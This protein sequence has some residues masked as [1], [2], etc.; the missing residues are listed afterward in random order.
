[1]KELTQPSSQVSSPSIGELATVD[2]GRKTGLFGSL[3]NDPRVMFY[4]LLD[5][6]ESF[7]PGVSE[8]LQK[9]IS[10]KTKNDELTR[11]E[12]SL[13]DRAV[14]D[15]VYE[16]RPQAKV[17]EPVDHEDPDALKAASGELDE[18]EL[19]VEDAEEGELPLGGD[20]LGEAP[21]ALRPPIEM[22]EVPTFWW[23]RTTAGLPTR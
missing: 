19:E 9:L 16:K 23:L 15:F 12:L 3:I 21:V 7:E 18:D 6:P 11:E 1:L 8:L 14:I 22:P 17:E 20:Q 2:P 4:A 13:L 5:R 10:G